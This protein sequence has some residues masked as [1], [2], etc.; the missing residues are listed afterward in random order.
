MT[1]QFLGQITTLYL[2]RSCLS[3]LLFI[4][5]TP[6]TGHLSVPAFNG[7][8]S[9]SPTNPSTGLGAMTCFGWH[10]SLHIPNF[11]QG[12][13]QSGTLVFSPKVL[14]LKD[15]WTAHLS[16]VWLI[17]LTTWRIKMYT[18]KSISGF[19]MS[20]A[21]SLLFS[22]CTLWLQQC[23]D[24]YLS[25]LSVLPVCPAIVNLN[26]PPVPVWFSPCKTRKLVLFK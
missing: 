24:V 9:W 12:I 18:S 1:V 23:P 22:I 2:F 14:S 20:F 13:G 15:G 8:S 10:M 25:S 5:S 4:T 6:D 7:G 3:P 16:K 17:W 11:Q 26:A 19:G 21:G